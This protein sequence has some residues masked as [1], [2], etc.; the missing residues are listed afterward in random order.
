MGSTFWT[1]EQKSELYD[2]AKSG[3]SASS[4][5]LMIGRTRN[6]VI[7]QLHRTG[8]GLCVH[9]TSPWTAELGQRAWDLSQG[10]MSNN[11]IAVELAIGVSGADVRAKIWNMKAAKAK[12]AARQAKYTAGRKNAPASPRRAPRPIRLRVEPRVLGLRFENLKAGQ[13]RYPLGEL[14]DE[15]QFWCGAEIERGMPYCSPHCAM[16]YRAPGSVAD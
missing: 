3:L 14:Y 15:P 4:I 5:G 11:D 6:A 8:S 16:S 10:G 12:R 2:L 13:C 1:A 7:G 9:N